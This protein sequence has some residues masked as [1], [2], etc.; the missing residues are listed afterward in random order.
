MVKQEIEETIARFQKTPVDAGKLADVKTRHRYGFLMNLDTP[1]RVAGALAYPIAVTGGID[2][3]AALLAAIDTVTA[4]DVMRAAKT[5][6][7][8]ERRTVV[9]LKGTKQ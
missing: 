4:D 8:P 6:F 9:V 2:A 1:D 7:V 5:Y 3:V